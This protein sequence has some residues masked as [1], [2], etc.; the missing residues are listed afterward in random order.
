MGQTDNGADKTVLV[1]SEL[2]K[3]YERGGR[4]FWPVNGV[5]FT[6]TRGTF[7]TLVGR[8]GSG[9]STL[10]AMMV[11]LLTSDKGSVTLMGKALEALDETARS[12][13]RNQFVGYVP[14]NVALLATLNVLDNVRL[15]WYLSARGA[16]PEGRAMTLLAELGLEGLAEQMPEALSGGECRRVALARALMVN[17]SII[18]ADEPTASLDAETSEAVVARLR[19][20]ARDGAAVLSVTHDMTGLGPEDT[21]YQMAQGVVTPVAYDDLVGVRGL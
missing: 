7:T 6:L 11:G 18:I 14:Q 9:K 13:L 2:A 1:A 21:I 15:P 4:T 16:E 5:S 8:S 12:H 19:Q 3:R 17:P 20:A 10:I